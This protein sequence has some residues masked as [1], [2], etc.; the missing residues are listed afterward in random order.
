[1]MLRRP[2]PPP[3]AAVTRVAEAMDWVALEL[4]RARMAREKFP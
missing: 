3:G 4:A 2:P 1:V